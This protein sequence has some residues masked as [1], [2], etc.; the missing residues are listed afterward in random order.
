MSDMK[1]K[2]QSALVRL[3]IS[4]RKI[5]ETRGYSK[6]TKSLKAL[7]ELIKEQLTNANSGHSTRQV[8]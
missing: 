3:E 2:L 4:S 1:E 8:R 7:E 6:D 5:V